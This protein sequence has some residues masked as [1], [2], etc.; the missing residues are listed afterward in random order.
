MPSVISS[1]AM[2][3][4]GVLIGGGLSVMAQQLTSR[5]NDRLESRRQNANRVE[6]RRQEQF[7]VIERYMATAQ[8][9]E[10]VAI[11]IHHYKM[12]DDETR[13]R[14]DFA[15]DDNW[16]AQKMVRILC[17][18]EFQDAAFSYTWKLDNAVRQGIGE[19][20]NVWEFLLPSREA[21]LNAAH[22]ELDRLGGNQGMAAAPLPGLSR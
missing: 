10:R 2:P 22:A 1:A 8:A 20:P 15:V 18:K 3:L 5:S 6:A 17:S 11:D 4:I 9:A 19:A 7:S 21:F 13:R 14:G 16:L 12:D